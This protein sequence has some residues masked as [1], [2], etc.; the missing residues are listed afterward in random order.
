MKIINNLKPAKKLQPEFAHLY[1]D[2]VLYFIDFNLV[3]N[4]PPWNYNLSK[5]EVTSGHQSEETVLYGFVPEV[6]WDKICDVKIT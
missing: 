1:F 5:S 3:G 2:K 4:I 6:Y